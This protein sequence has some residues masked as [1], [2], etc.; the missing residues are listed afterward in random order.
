MG[1]AVFPKHGR[2]VR[3]QTKTS[4]RVEQNM[5]GIKTAKKQA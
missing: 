4:E 5:E 2:D 1:T 3:R